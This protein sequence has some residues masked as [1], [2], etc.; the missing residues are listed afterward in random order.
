[1]R[2]QV[3]DGTPEKVAMPITGHR[4]RLAFN[5]D[6]IAAP[7]DLRAAV[8]R[9]AARGMRSSSRDQQRGGGSASARSRTSRVH[10][11]EDV[12]DGGHRMPAGYD[13]A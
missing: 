3:N 1:V 6:H 4:P 12:R 9:I 11:D 8:T 10:T 13:S 5:R 2:N 7:G